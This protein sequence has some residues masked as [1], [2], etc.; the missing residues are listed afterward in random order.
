MRYEIIKITAFFSLLVI[1][2][3]LLCLLSLQMRQ[4]HVRLKM[5]EKLEHSFLQSITLDKKNV[6]WVKPDKEIRIGNKLFD[7]KHY[8]IENEKIFLTGLY[9]H[10]ER[11][12]EDQIKDL[13]SNTNPQS[14]SLI[15]EK[16]FQLLQS[17]FS[18]ELSFTD[19]STISHN[20]YCEYFYNHPASLY[21]NVLTPPP[22]Q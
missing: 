21:K 12:I 22:Q 8:R 3:P 6:Q 16:I 9:D 1:T 17:F 18:S 2:M 13:G 15:L 4:V 19:F 5:K 11:L 20:N 10:E 14:K 7:V